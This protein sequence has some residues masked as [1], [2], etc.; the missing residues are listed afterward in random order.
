MEIFK[1][2]TASL[3]LSPSLGF[4]CTGGVVSSCN[5]ISFLPRMICVHF[6]EYESK[7]PRKF[8]L[9]TEVAPACSLEEEGKD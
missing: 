3:S 7:H 9:D 2:R 6:W 4:Y 1:R 5:Q 8:Q